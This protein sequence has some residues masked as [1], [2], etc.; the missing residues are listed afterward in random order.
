MLN[1]IGY[2]L[3]D[4]LLGLLVYLA[5][6]RFYMQL[7]RAPFRNPVGQ[8]A[9]AFTD[10][11]VQPLRRVIPGWKGLD[12]SSLVLAFVV[13]LGIVIL[14]QILFMPPTVAGPG[15]A[16]WIVVGLLEVVRKSL[17]LLVLV[18]LVDVILSWVNP[19]TP[20]AP[21]VR[22]ITGPLYGVFRR[23]IPAIGGFDLAPL[24]LILVVQI[25][26]ILL[27][28]LQSELMRVL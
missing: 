10:W 1:Q 3:V 11:G 17:H 21:I 18:V 15:V 23:V 20:F 6:L 5:L 25:L 13:Q 28:G 26:F 9:I 4:T 19:H 2:L 12:L 16:E 14:V 22:S 24:F 7:F 27:N 8:F